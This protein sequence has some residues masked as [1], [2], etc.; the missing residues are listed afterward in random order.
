MWQIVRH[1]PVA[2]FA[3]VLAHVLF[4]VVLFVSFKFSDHT[5]DSSAGKDK[6]EI[7]NATAV[8]EKAVQA[9]LRRLKNADKRKKDAAHR[10]ELQR[11][12]EQRRLVELKKK[13]ATEER[14]RQQQ[15]VA[16]E[17]RLV[18]LQKQR[19]QAELEQ[20]KEEQRLAELEKQRRE[21][22]DRARQ[23]ELKKQLDAENAAREAAAKEAAR[24]SEIG[25]YKAQIKHSVYRT[26]SVPG[27]AKKDMRCVVKVRLIPSGDVLGVD[28][29]KGSGDSAFDQ[30]VIKAIYRA[31]PLP[32]PPAGSGL[33][34]DF[35]ELE[36]G[37]SPSSRS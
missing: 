9:E 29:V 35:R 22:E 32:V 20:K 4:F 11:K 13:R 33:F 16:D 3:A 30:S 10:V 1:H 15:K 12:R 28:V 7:I 24:Q 6:M 17:K 26:W 36:L 19:K 21:E 18:E 27:S 8:D 31:A 23:T 34:S 37:F 14:K 25:K 5:P 2:V